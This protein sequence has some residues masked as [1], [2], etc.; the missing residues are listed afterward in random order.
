MSNFS[1]TLESAL[2]HQQRTAWDVTADQFAE[3]QEA[4][5]RLQRQANRL[6][7]ATD[8]LAASVLQRICESDI[9]MAERAA[10]SAAY[11]AARRSGELATPEWMRTRAE[12]YS[13]TLTDV[14]EALRQPGAPIV[15]FTTGMFADWSRKEQPFTCGYAAGA[16]TGIFYEQGHNESMGY[17]Y[18]LVTVNE[19]GSRT[20]PADAASGARRSLLVS[21]MYAEEF[22][23]AVVTPDEAA[24]ALRRPPDAPTTHLVIGH[25]AVQSLFSDLT[26]RGG[27]GPDA[28]RLVG[29][30]LMRGYRPQF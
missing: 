4:L 18:H 26:T 14:N 1:R 16:G 23:D 25:E 6:Q 28:E 27:G 21:R 7:R 22:A 24:Q 15:K 20:A 29:H 2:T 12:L 11:H 9:P 13:V 8:E 3:T 19:L 30:A 5:T 10:W 17:H